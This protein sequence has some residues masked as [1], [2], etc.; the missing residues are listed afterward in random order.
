MKRA[1]IVHGWGGT[2]EQGFK[3]WLKKELEARDYVAEVPALPDTDYPKIDAWVD[4]LQKVITRPDEDTL[5]VGHSLGAPAIL[6][7]LERLPEGTRVGKVVLVAPVMDC[8]T[9]MEPEKIAVVQSWFDTPMNFEKIKKSAPEI[10]AFFSDNDPYIPLTSEKVFKE[11]FGGR[12]IIEHAMGHYSSD[13]GVTEVP[14]VLEEITR[15]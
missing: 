2:P 6:H 14:T 4:E 10:V 7:F 8:I 13:T 5:L 9:G 11:R 15:Q 3:P 1:F 12:T